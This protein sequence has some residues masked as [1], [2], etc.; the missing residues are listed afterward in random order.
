MRGLRLPGQRDE[1]V[2]RKS[3]RLAIGHGSAALVNRE[4]LPEIM[5]SQ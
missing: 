5:I 4:K 2:N 1:K 3:S